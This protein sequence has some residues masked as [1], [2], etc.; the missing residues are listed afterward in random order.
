[1][2][3][4]DGD[5]GDDGDNQKGANED[6]NEQKDVRGNPGLARVKLQSGL[7]QAVGEGPHLRCE[8]ARAFLHRETI[9]APCVV[10]ECGLLWL[11]NGACE[12]VQRQVQ[13]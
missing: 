9:L 7:L 3:A 10:L 1:M 11:R 8:A 4:I 13:E 5:G 6:Y 2:A 12:I